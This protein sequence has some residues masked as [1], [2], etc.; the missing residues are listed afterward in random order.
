LEILRALG[1]KI[2][3]PTVKEFV[4]RYCEELSDILPSTERLNKICTYLA[5]M[6]CHNYNLM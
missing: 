6:A 5:K 3:F 1:Y 2:G 4:D